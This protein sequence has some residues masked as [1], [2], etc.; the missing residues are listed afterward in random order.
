M[1]C[2]N[3]LLD[4]GIPFFEASL[5]EEN[6]FSFEGKNILINQNLSYDTKIYR[7][8]SFIDLIRILEGRLRLTKRGSFSDCH[9]RGEYVAEEI[10]VSQKETLGRERIELVRKKKKRFETSMQLYASCWTLEKKEIFPMWR[11]YAIDKFSVRIQTTIGDLLS[12]IRLE[13][14]QKM[15]CSPMVYGEEKNRTK[16]F[17]ILFYKTEEYKIENEFRL[18]LSADSCSEIFYLPI[19]WEACIEDIMFSPFI[20]PDIA[21]YI[22][23]CLLL[24][25]PSLQFKL[26]P[27][28][29]IEY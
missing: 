11:A 4:H 14:S 20:E 1:N 18:Y 12:S 23:S 25:H 7:I 21:N 19:N 28:Q 26:S 17:D 27:S 2:N 15:F 22:A 5:K 6:N 24:K 29:I 3:C 8:I 13:S 9:E 10:K 16:A